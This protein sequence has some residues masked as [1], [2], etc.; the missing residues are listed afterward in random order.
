M[1]AAGEGGSVV[2]YLGNGWW[3]AASSH[4]TGN[5]KLSM[6]FK[7]ASNPSLF[8]R[9]IIGDI[10]V[11]GGPYAIGDFNR[12]NYY[13]HGGTCGSTSSTRLSASGSWP[14]LN[15]TPALGIFWG[16]KASAFQLDIHILGCP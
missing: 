11:S 2:R 8:K 3:R 7:D 12:R 15:T 10:V 4:F 9:A 14:T 13:G 5:Q 6:G 16:D 1:Q